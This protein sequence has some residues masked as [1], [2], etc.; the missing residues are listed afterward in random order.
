LALNPEIQTRRSDLDEELTK[1]IKHYNY[2]A[3]L[4]QWT[5]TL[6]M[7][8]AVCSSAVAGFG[9]LFSKPSELLQKVFGALALL[10]AAIALIGTTM[11]FQEKAFWHFRKQE[12]L[13]G[14]RQRLRYE[15]P[16]SATADSV[17]AISEAYRKL[18]EKMTQEWEREMRFDFNI[19]RRHKN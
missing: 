3:E 12:A 7:I 2:L 15:L 14:L 9:G 6:L 10:P 17:A 8:I 1:D 4:N 16:E 5:S 13:L 11:K 19:L 18:T